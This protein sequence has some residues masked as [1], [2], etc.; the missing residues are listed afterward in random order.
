M[1]PFL[2]CF[3]LELNECD[4]DPCL[5]GGTCVDGVQNY[6]CNCAS[7]TEHGVL[8][9]YTGRNCGTGENQ[10]RTVA[11]AFST[12]DTYIILL[13]SIVVDNREAPYVTKSPSSRK[14]KLNDKICLTCSATGNPTPII[15]WYKDGKP[16]YGPQAI[17]DVF[18]IPEATPNERGFYYCEAFSSFGDPSKSAEALILIEGWKIKK[19]QIILSVT[20]LLCMICQ[21]IIQFC[22]YCPVS[23]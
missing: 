3:L 1:Y 16:I 19:S 22:R 15:R 4:P 13:Y 5:N 10:N 20:E 14:V 7:F 8:I 6:T 23:D 17:G 9:Y 11:V 21:C 18:V 12:H 2:H